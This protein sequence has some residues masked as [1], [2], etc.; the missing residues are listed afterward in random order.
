MA[1]FL[2]YW[3]KLR[4]YVPGLGPDQAQDYIQSAWRDICDADQEWSF[5]AA[6]EYWLAPAIITLASVAVEQNSEIVEL[7]VGDL[8]EIGGLNNP[9]LT[10][11]QAK[12]GQGGPVYQILE[13][14][15][16]QVTD[17][18][19]TATDTTLTSADGP[20]TS[21]DVGK[22]I[23]VVGA[24]A[25]GGD[26]QTTIASYTSPTE[27][28]LTDAAGTTVPSDG[29]VTWG[30]T[31][32]LD[33]LYRESTNS[34]TQMTIAR[35]YYSPLSTDFAR[36]DH[37]YD[38]ILGYEFAWEIGTP[39][40]ID[41]MDPQRSAAGNPY[42]LFFRQ[43]DPDTGLPIYEMWP[44]PQAQ[45][46]Y[47]VK[48]WR[49]GGE[50]ATDD[51]ALPPQIPEEVLLMRAR[52]LAYEW[53]MVADT[54]RDRR[55]SYANALGYVRSKYSTEGQPGRPLGL[56][57]KAKLQDKSKYRKSFIRRQRR[58]PMGYPID[59][60]FSQSHDTGMAGWTGPY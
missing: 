37:L 8:Q 18:A 56:L 44:C 6:T 58:S 19:I 17:G 11:R 21:D 39:D 28:E 46:A 41:R 38:P 52:L 3:N 35:F 14:D 47:T 5:L 42:R 2:E 33:R 4:S 23:Y 57:E 20:F 43:F 16:Q 1:S 9:P 30:S 32:T 48:Y 12:F 54:D 13:S 7:T 45:R 50:F 59:S 40:E 25:G 60:R 24:G 22:L 49:K 15:V 34:N 53:A 36:I 31:I 10:S 26:L 27:V 51:E 29:V 55:A